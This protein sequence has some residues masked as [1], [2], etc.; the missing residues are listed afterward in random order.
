MGYTGHV[1]VAIC[2]SVKRAAETS[3]FWLM[4]LNRGLEIETDTPPAR[5]ATKGAQSNPIKGDSRR[6]RHVSV[7]GTRFSDTR[8]RAPA[9]NPSPSGAGLKNVRRAPVS[10]PYRKRELPA[11]R[12]VARPPGVGHAPHPSDPFSGRERNARTVATARAG[13]AG[14]GGGGTAPP[15]ARPRPCPHL[16]FWERIASPVLRSPNTDKGPSIF[17]AGNTS[18]LTHTADN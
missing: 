13:G 10:L 11:R 5:I 15:S 14:V 16:P 9:A 18:S 4:V 1:T 17:V 2:S 3:L 12:E 7:L 6:A 8:A